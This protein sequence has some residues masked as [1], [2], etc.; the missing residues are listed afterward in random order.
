MTTAPV[1]EIRRSGDAR[2]DWTDAA[3]VLATLTLVGAVAGAVS[4]GVLGRLA[5]MLLAVLNPEATGVR[6]DD[7]FLIG[8]FTLSGSLQLALAGVQLGVTGAF[9]Y[10][11]FRGLMVGPAWFRLLS[12]SL[13]PGLV[14]GAL[15]VHTDGVDFTALDPAW[16]A[17]ALFVAVPTCY[18]AML[19]VVGERLLAAGWAPPL[20]L[21]LL[22]LLPWVVLL[23]LTAALA[24]GFAALRALRR[25]D[26][27]RSF[28][29]SPWPA[30]A[31]RGMLAALV[32]VAVADLVRDV[33]TLS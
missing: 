32:V 21:L 14:V 7:G 29:A 8:Q 13:G 4:V 6:S 20:P 23:P 25:T 28:L 15:V 17:A 10:V 22:G 2:A 26:G 19:H 33:A 11:V 30:W 16:L 27:G 12:I 24:G 31:V 1:Q 9:F 18:V 3:R 5:M